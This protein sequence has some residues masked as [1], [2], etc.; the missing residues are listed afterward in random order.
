MGVIGYIV[1]LSMCSLTFLAEGGKKK[2]EGEANGDLLYSSHP[3]Q[4][5]PRRWRINLQRYANHTSSPSSRLPLSTR[6]SKKRSKRAITTSVGE[7]PRSNPPELDTFFRDTTCRHFSAFHGCTILPFYSKKSEEIS[8]ALK[9]KA[10]FCS[11]T[12]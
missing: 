1:K 7:K 4:Q 3:R 9:E 6:D 2:K 8:W 5:H 11:Y 12:F 10:S